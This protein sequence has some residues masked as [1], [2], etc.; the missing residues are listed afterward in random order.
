MVCVG[1]SLRRCGLF[2]PVRTNF[3]TLL[4]H[5]SSPLVPHRA[6][7]ELR[8]AGGWRACGGAKGLAMVTLFVAGVK[9]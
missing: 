6:Q 3:V 1:L 9:P 7:K 8:R 4:Q 5:A 2:I